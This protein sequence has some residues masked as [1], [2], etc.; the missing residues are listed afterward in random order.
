[1]F[2]LLGIALSTPDDGHYDRAEQHRADRTR[3]L[4]AAHVVYPARFVHGVPEAPALPT[5]VWI[6]KPIADPSDR[7]S[8]SLKQCMPVSQ[9][10]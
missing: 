7:S 1:L 3:V 8:N 10:R 6:N 9:T 5:T 4:V 2:A